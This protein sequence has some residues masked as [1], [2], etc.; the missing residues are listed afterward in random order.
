[1]KTKQI[2]CIITAAIFCALCIMQYK[3]TAQKELPCR[4]PKVS[5]EAVQKLID[6]RKKMQNRM[7]ATSTQVRVYFHIC[8]D[9]DGASPGATEE[10]VSKEFQAMQADYAA[11]GICFVYAGLG[12]TNSTL[13]NHINLDTHSDADDLFEAKTIPGCLNIFYLDTIRGENQSSGGRIGGYSFDIPGTFC[14]VSKASLGGHTSSHETG[15]CLGLFHT[16]STKGFGFENI[17]GSNCGVAGDLICDTN[18]DPYAFNADDDDCFSESNGFYNGACSDPEGHSNYSPPYTNIM[19]YWHHS[20]ETFT[21]DQLGAM[22]FTIDDDDDIAALASAND[23]TIF[24]HTYDFGFVYKSAISSITTVGS[25]EF[26]QITQ[27][28][29]FAK[30]II[31]SAGFHATPSAQGFTLIRANECNETFVSNITQQTKSDVTKQQLIE[32][33][34][35]A[36]CKVFPNPSSGLFT[37]Q[38]DSKEKF[39]ASIVVRNMMGQVIYRNTP[40]EYL[41]N[42][43][44]LIN[45][46]G[47]TKGIYLVEIIAGEKRITSKVLIQ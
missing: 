10:Q 19:S 22:S 1:M 26:R 7:Q 21:N 11:G 3:A 34:Q 35:Q 23:L 29:L 8:T 47:K 33:N 42:L 17:S 28:G 13:L 20:P 32:A 36:S 18:A 37:V 12:Y 45:I 39:T 25:L 2:N 41:N 30:K 40:K 15:H 43:N 5:R 44:E 9:N 27:T 31:L 24:Q 4:E 46:S 14:I 16:F 38:Y 6:S